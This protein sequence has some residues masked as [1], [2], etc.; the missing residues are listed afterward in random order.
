M[1]LILALQGLLHCESSIQTELSQP[2]NVLETLETEACYL[3]SDWLIYWADINYFN[4]N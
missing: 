4:N 3:A 1:K 2:D